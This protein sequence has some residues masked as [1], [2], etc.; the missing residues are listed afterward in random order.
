MA[1]R[2]RAWRRFLQ[3]PDPT[4]LTEL[5][6]PALREAVRYDRCCA[7]FSS[8]VLATAARG[9]GPFVERLLSAK[10]APSVP[11]IRLFV[12]EEL[13]REDVEA[14]LHGNGATLLARRLNSRLLAPRDAI[15][16]D[17]LALLGLL[18][19][20]GLLD[21]R[22][23]V[24]REAGGILH[25]KF[26]IVW[27]A[28]GD[29]VVFSGSGNETGSALSANYESLEIRPSWVDEEAYQFRKAEF[30]GLWSDTSPLVRSLT[31][32][33][34]VKE[35]LIKYATARSGVTAPAASEVSTRK[36]LEAWMRWHFVMESPWFREGGPNSDATAPVGLWPHQVRVVED[37]A[38]SWPAGRLLC[39]EVGMGKT[40]EAIQVLRRLL[41]GRG[42]ARALL[43]V[44]ASL[45]EQWQDE[46]REKGGLVVP[47]LE[48][49]NSLIWPDGT[50]E[51]VDDLAEALTQPLLIA[52]RELARLPAN[53]ERFLAASPW[54][55]VLLDEAHA[56]RRKS[57]EEREFNSATQLLELLR[58]LQLK[59]VARGL[60]LLSATPIQTHPW[61]PWDLLAV[62]GEGAPWLVDFSTVRDFYGALSRVGL[63]A[64]PIQDGK[65]L[66][67]VAE[68]D[69]DFPA[70]SV[71]LGMLPQ[72][73]YVGSATQRSDL[74]KELREGAPLGRRMHRNTRATLRR[75]FELG[76]LDRPPAERAIVDLQ[77]DFSHFEEREVYDKITGYVTRR[78]EELEREKPGKGFVMTVYRRRATSSPAAFRRS[79]ERR[80]TGLK[81][82]AA[83]VAV[84][85]DDEVDGAEQTD[86]EEFLGSDSVGPLSSSF[87]TD[88]A[89]A[90]RELLEVEQLLQASRNLG[91]RDSK[92]EGFYGALDRAI[93]D[94]RPCLVFSEFLDTV[95]Y[96]RDR[97]QPRFGSALGTYSGQGGEV[98]RDG[99]WKRVRKETITEELN[100]GRLRVLLCT[101]AA[102]EG[103]NLQAAGAVINYDLPWNPSRVEQRIGRI[104]RI[105]QRLPRVR[106]VNLF[107][108]HSVDERVYQVLRA[109]CQMF[110]D[111]VGAMPPVLAVARRILLRPGTV[112]QT[113]LDELSATADEVNTEPVALEAFRAE[114]GPPG[115]VGRPGVA[116]VDL[117]SAQVLVRSALGEVGE[118]TRFGFSS[119]ELANDGTLLPGGPF[120]V[121]ARSL[122]EPLRHSGEHPPLV[123]G[124][125]EQ[126]GFRAVEARWVSE[127]QV[128]AVTSSERLEALLGTWNGSRIPAHVAEAATRDADAVARGRVLAMRTRARSVARSAL[129]RQVDAASKRLARELARVLVC[130][131]PSA[132]DLNLTFQREMGRAG[133]VGVLLTQAFQLVSYPA[134]DAA[135]IRWAKGEVEGLGPNQRT[136][137]L[138]GT[139]LGAALRDPRWEARATLE[140]FDQLWP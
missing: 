110:E 121:E 99:G 89:I 95:E 32:P 12:N 80:A 8:S 118:G 57:Q 94:G 10:T 1:F 130:L 22:V 120:G 136:N 114:E 86:I 33:D 63:G 88:P 11:P 18:V 54:D 4:L 112:S 40:V 44:P 5:Y 31:V 139:P 111:Y 35:R 138:L 14:I 83:G 50:K 75:Y 106:I 48:G 24:M 73:L 122:A 79:L 16:A 104:D 46:L 62:L 20:R 119:S 34:A 115:D 109:R 81:Q 30:E 27:D 15:E 52:S 13:Q 125:F 100:A 7:Y 26:G 117:Y 70:L 58:Q 123:L 66:A 25:A 78:F 61:E 107:L 68:S 43:L 65:A 135:Q 28:S 17:R 49:Q 133:Q 93:D 101:D 128:E 59:A 103:L 129:E 126:G 96:L 56:A 2:D 116:K 84:S 77:Y 98:W 82:V 90:R 132:S 69:P 29:A 131:D 92:L 67:R 9:F 41:A 3:A 113:D 91:E 140:K 87:P 127:G 39:D 124:V 64:L 47:R 76:L 45:Q 97:L 137:L 21:L 102:S 37:A 53:A 105:G 60:L 55:L 6:E 19:Q 38:A 23:G 134:W 85:A 71:P 42:V 74:A 51:R 108:K 72:R 36:R